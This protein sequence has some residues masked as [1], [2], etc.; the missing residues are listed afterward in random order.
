M[1]HRVNANR[2]NV[3]LQNLPRYC[4]CLPLPFWCPFC[5]TFEI[6]APLNACLFPVSTSLPRRMPSSLPG[7][8]SSSF[9]P[10]LSSCH[11]YYHLANQPLHILTDKNSFLEHPEPPGG[12]VFSF[13]VGTSLCLITTLSVCG[14]FFPPECEFPRAWRLGYSALHCQHQAPAQR[15]RRCMLTESNLA[16][17]RV[18]GPGE[19]PVMKERH[20]RKGLLRCGV[21]GDLEE[22]GQ[23]SGTR[24]LK[25]GGQWQIEWT[26][27]QKDR[28]SK[29]LQ[30]RGSRGCRQGVGCKHS[31]QDT[32]EEG[33]S[34][35][36]GL[37]PGGPQGTNS[38]DS[39]K[40]FGNGIVGKDRASGGNWALLSLELPSK[41]GHSRTSWLATILCSYR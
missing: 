34:T 24:R 35:W 40:Y 13:N 14:V 23:P 8:P 5:F 39:Q 11:H 7:P 38:E 41:Q 29:S 27:E 2:P 18:L 33:A 16:E 26:I 37:A 20:E 25:S 12:V 28:E 1:R 6:P 19:W 22:V 10:S 15:R 4:S 36:K 32:K 21:G 31:P 30:S 17:W 9:S 3:A